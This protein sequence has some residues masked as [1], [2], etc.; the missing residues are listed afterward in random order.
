MTPLQL[1]YIING[2]AVFIYRRHDGTHYQSVHDFSKFG[3][4]PVETVRVKLTPSATVEDVLNA[5]EVL[6]ALSHTQKEN[7]VM[8]CPLQK[9]YGDIICIDGM[10]WGLTYSDCAPPD[11]RQAM[12][13]CDHCKN[14]KLVRSAHL[15][16]VREADQ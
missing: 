7:L 8:P 4:N 14:Q 2:A 6:A 10:L 13:Q 3:V 15:S 11:S 12:G 16:H 9:K 5:P 1:D